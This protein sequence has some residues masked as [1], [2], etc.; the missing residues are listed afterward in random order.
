[1]AKKYS[2]CLNIFLVFAIFTDISDGMQMSSSQ[3]AFGLAIPG[4]L[5]K[6]RDCSSLRGS[7]AAQLLDLGRG[8]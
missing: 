2:G 1:M 7:E 5:W 4:F 3:L 6:F 8:E